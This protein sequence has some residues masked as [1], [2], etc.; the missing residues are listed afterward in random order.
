MFFV[1]G[2]TGQVG[3]A[4]ARLLLAGGHAVRT[5]ARDPR[6]AAAWSQKGVDVRRGDFSDAAAVAAAM[7]GVEGA[8]LM[9]PPLLAPAPGFPEAKAI[10]ESFREAL[11]R[12]PPPRLVVLSSIGSQQSSGLGLITTTHLLEQAL[13]DLPFPTAFL[14]AGSFLENYTFSLKAAASTG[15]FDT[16]RSPTDRPVPM[17]ATED[18][19]K[20]VARRLVGGWSGKLIVELGSPMSPDDLARAMSE[21]LGRPVKA[22]SIPRAQ[23]TA[24]LEARGMAPGTTGPFEEMEDSFNSGWI[25]FGVP[26]AERVAATVT[27][28]QVFAH[29]R[30]AGVGI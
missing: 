17:I 4:A 16:Y 11:R 24:R 3:G 7:E 20:E 13:C 30:K 14:R 2:I 5:L 25:D 23:W 6:K 10:I 19:G 18:I 26:G 28:A 27:P 1:S 29:A 15:W 8:Y 9:L 12:A 21:A 22:R